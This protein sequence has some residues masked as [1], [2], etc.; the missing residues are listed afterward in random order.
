M[1]F[2]ATGEAARG[3]TFGRHVLDVPRHVDCL[4]GPRAIIRFRAQGAATVLEDLFPL[5]RRHRE[6][7]AAL[8]H[9]PLP[10]GATLA[11]LTRDEWYTG[12]SSEAS[13]LEAKEWIEAWVKLTTT[14]GQ[15]EYDCTHYMGVYL[16]PMSVPGSVVERSRL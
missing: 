2:A 9:V 12:K 8:L 16:L 15:G 4:S 1:V 6:S 7:L 14:R 11:G 13:L 5:S 10:D 3:R